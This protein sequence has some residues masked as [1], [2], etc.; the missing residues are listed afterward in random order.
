MFLNS[1]AFLFSTQKKG[2]TLTE[3]FQAHVHH[4]DFWSR[5]ICHLPD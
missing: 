3:Y 2:A 4:F 1:L 5:Q